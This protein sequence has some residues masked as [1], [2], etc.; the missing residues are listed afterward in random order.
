MYLMEVIKLAL[1]DQ[2]GQTTPQNQVEVIQPV[3]DVCMN[4]SCMFFNLSTNT[5]ALEECLFLNP[6]AAVHLSITRKC[7]VCG[8]AMTVFVG[9]ASSVCPS[10]ASNIRRAIQLMHSP[11]SD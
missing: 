8:G 5:C 10:C 9:S 6:P 2:L 11:G 3:A 4:A 7:D 1:T